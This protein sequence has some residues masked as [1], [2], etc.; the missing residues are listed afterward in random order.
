MSPMGPT[1]GGRLCTSLWIVI[2]R[3]LGRALELLGSRRQAALTGK[4]G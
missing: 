1:T 4:A 3:E 2:L